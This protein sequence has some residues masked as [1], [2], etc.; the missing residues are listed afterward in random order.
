MKH[1]IIPLVFAA[2]LWSCKGNDDES[3]ERVT[4]TVSPESISASAERGTFTVNVST[5]GNEWHIG[6]V[7]DFIFAEALDTTATAG[8]LAITVSANP[9]L[10][11]RTGTVTILSD[12]VSQ[13]IAITQAGAD[14]STYY[15]PDGYSLVW[16][17]EFDGTEITSTTKREV[18][19]WLPRSKMAG[20]TSPV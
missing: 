4:V 5:T 20:S 16:H 8:S 7:S 17:D 15:V 1:F 2:T 9:T 13:I 11:F 14:S 3:N 19:H 6:D 10:D 18:A 12:T